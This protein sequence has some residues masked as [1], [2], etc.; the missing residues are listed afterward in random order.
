LGLSDIY[1][2]TAL[3]NSRSEN[4]MKKIGMVKRGI[5]DHPLVNDGSP[6]KQHLLYKISREEKSQKGP[7]LKDKK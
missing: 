5:F 7:V 2:F 3:G 1:A 6:L 4:V